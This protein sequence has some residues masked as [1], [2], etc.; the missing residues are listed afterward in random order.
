MG[1]EQEDIFGRF[2]RRKPRQ[3]RSRLLV[4]AVIDAFDELL[5]RDEEPKLGGVAA[6]AGIGVGSF[7]EYFTGRD[8]LLGAFIGRVTRDNFQRLLA[9]FDDGTATAKGTRE[10]ST[11]TEKSTAHSGTLE[12]I[13]EQMT[14]HVAATYLEH[15]RRMRVIFVGVARLGLVDV[16][17]E[18]RDRFARELAARTL[19]FVPHADLHELEETMVVVCDAVIGMVS[20]ALYRSEINLER[21]SNAMAQLATAVIRARHPA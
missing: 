13:A 7:Y 9:A 8:A 16:V 20:G 3:S 1:E 6:R 18:E 12:T 10:K 14:A 11:V 4:E 19:P 2:L 5:R 15:P 21:E 17:V